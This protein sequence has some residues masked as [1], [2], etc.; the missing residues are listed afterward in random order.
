[1]RDNFT[2]KQSISDN[3]RSKTILFTPPSSFPK[4]KTEIRKAFDADYQISLAFYQKALQ[5]YHKEEFLIATFMMQQAIQFT[6]NA[7]IKAF[8]GLKGKVD[9]FKEI[10]ESLQS[11]IPEIENVFPGKSEKD[12][13]LLEHLK[14]VDIN[15]LCIPDFEISEEEVFQLLQ[16]TEELQILAKKAFIARFG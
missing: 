1:M 13:V 5:C 14:N 15:P 16:K 4:T 8:S 9:D 3:D 6:C 12:Y 11:Q 2:N 7:L 10:I